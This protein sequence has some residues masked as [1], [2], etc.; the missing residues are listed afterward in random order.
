MKARLLARGAPAKRE[1]ARL[2]RGAAGRGGAHLAQRDDHLAQE[3]VGAQASASPHADL[4]GS[5]KLEASC[6]SITMGCWSLCPEV[7]EHWRVQVS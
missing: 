3:C 2:R 7:C 5:L 4:R 6:C 1:C